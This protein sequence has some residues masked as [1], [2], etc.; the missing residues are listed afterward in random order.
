MVNN[1]IIFICNTIEEANNSLL[2]G[3]CMNLFKGIEE[4]ALTQNLNWL[5][6]PSG[7]NINSKGLEIEAPGATEFFNDPENC[8]LNSSAPYLY[9]YVKG[10]FALTTRIDIN[11]LAMFDA[12]CLMVMSDLN[13]WAK[14]CYENWLTGPSVVS[15]VTREMSDDCPAVKVGVQ[16]PYLKI[17]RSGNCFG[18]HY[19]LDGV[20]WNIIRFFSMDIPEEI[21][22]GVVA[23]SPIGNGCIVNFEFLE[24]ELRK[25]ESA[26]F[27]P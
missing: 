7:W 12:G 14:F 17:L 4:K 24:L 19:S 3:K 8:K 16:K 25:I 6:Q 26:K 15:V 11:M 27:V 20:A 5:N 9:T 21:K 23:Q 1:Y 18:F 13:N 2:G 22:V 10:D